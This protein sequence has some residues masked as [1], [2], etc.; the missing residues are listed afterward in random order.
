M[1][2]LILFPFS[3]NAREAITVI[4]AIN[5]QKKIWNV[6]GF[7][8]DDIALVRQEFR[9]I[10]VLGGREL[11]QKYPHASVLAVPGRPENHLKRK[12]RINSLLLPIERFVTLIHPLANLA[13]DTK[14]GYNTLIMAG[15][16]A[17]ANVTIGNHCVILPNSVLSHDVVLEDYCLVGSNVSI[18]G[19]VAVQSLCYIGSGSNLIHEIQVSEGTLVGLGSVVINSTDPYTI[20]AG[21]PANFIRS[22]NA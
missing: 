22:N 11:L 15:V 21:S 9:G 18:S 8:D 10:G 2:D 14:V 1:K 16:V 13:A 3:G 6:L 20:I 19:H 12:E 4:D 17:T 7:I 5:S